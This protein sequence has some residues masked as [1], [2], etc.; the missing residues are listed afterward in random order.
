MSDGWSIEGTPHN[1]AIW[2]HNIA[3]PLECNDYVV[4][5]LM[6]WNIR[7]AYIDNR[8]RGVIDG[9]RQRGFQT[10][11][12]DN[13]KTILFNPLPSSY[14]FR[15]ERDALAIGKAANNMEMNFPWMIKGYS[16]RLEDYPAEYLKRFKLIYLI[17][18]EVKDF[19]GFQDIVESLAKD[20]KIIIVSMGRGETWPLLDII[21]YWEKIE[22][23]SDLKPTGKGPIKGEARL[24]ADPTGQVPALGN[25]DILWAVMQG[26]DKK[27]PAIGYK[28][29]NGHK[30]YFVGL[31]LGQQI[32]KTHGEQIKA[33]L[34][35]LMDLAHPNKNI[36]PAAFPVET[37]E[38]KHDGFNFSYN[39]PQK[40]P[41]QISVTY[42][43]RWK[44]TVDGKPW[45]AYNMENL[46]YME[47][48]AGSHKVV[49]H[50][51]M[52]W[53]SWLGIA[54]SGFSLILVALFYFCFDY[55]DRIFDSLKANARK[56]IATIGE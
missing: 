34:E 30:V 22:T 41:V 1:R 38:W 52:T 47:L 32:N 51:G 7:S 16:N 5:N 55:F 39:S 19:T 2:Q 50:Y 4:R 13:E 27:V 31:A 18:P 11:K 48:P 21:P 43:P 6:V 3:I 9:M 42:T 33:I 40:A 35:Q 44:A 36:I 28:E 45:K 53:V 29:V 23:D 25:V 26:S 37:Q 12:T 10:V 24:E 56:S 17:E 20:G 8:L 49:F 15:Q 14:F 54:L 46:I